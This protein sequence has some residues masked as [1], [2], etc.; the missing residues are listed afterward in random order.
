MV[1]Y[2]VYSLYNDKW[3]LMVDGAAPSFNSIAVPPIPYPYQWDSTSKTTFSDI[4]SIREVIETFCI[5][6]ATI[7]LLALQIVEVKTQGLSEYNPDFTTAFPCDE[8]FMYDY[9]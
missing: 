6:I 9:R 8:N 7:E 3:L 4:K 5:S 1:R 2:A